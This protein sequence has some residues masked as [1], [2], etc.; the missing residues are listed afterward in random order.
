MSNTYTSSN[1]YFSYFL[2]S[3][4]TREQV[5]IAAGQVATTLNS[6]MYFCFLLN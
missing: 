4:V 6:S 2:P 3:F 5:H 1:Y